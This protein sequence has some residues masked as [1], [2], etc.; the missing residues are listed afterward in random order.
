MVRPLVLPRSVL[1]LTPAPDGTRSARKRIPVGW[2][3]CTLVRKDHDDLDRALVAMLTTATPVDELAALHGVLLLAFS[4][5]I[6]AER[7]ALET[8]CSRLA[9]PSAIRSLMAQT[10]HE[11]QTQR[12]QIA[13]L[14]DCRPGSDAW[15]AR[16]LELRVDVL[17]HASRAELSRWTI[18]DHVAVVERRELATRYTA[19]RFRVLGRTAPTM[20]L[21]AAV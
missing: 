15:Y 19:E 17:D 18:D 21:D 14:G 10:H 11:H 1:P 4:V 3:F 12:A 13:A 16:V 5:H 7:R 20:A 9:N 2:R 6:S 8:L